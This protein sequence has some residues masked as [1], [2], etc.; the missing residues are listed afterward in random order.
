ME[1][2]FFVGVVYHSKRAFRTEYKE[3]LILY[4]DNYQEFVDLVTCQVYTL[5]ESKKDYVLKETLIPTD[6]SEYRDDYLYLLFKYKDGI[7][8]KKRK[9]RIKNNVL[10]SFLNIR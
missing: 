5:D 3:K 9:L 6:V 2:N 7:M 4:S 8:N 10:E 1:N